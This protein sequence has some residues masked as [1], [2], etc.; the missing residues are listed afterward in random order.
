MIVAASLIPPL[1]EFGLPGPVR[2]FEFLL[3]ATFFLHIIFMNI[4]LGTAV[5][6]LPMWFA[7]KSRPHLADAVIRLVRFWPIA[8]SLTITTFKGTC[9]AIL[10]PGL[11]RSRSLPITA[12]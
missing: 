1:D 12:T 11:V 10:P 7:S 2:L 3:P 8:V 9:T 5:M 6:I 4:A